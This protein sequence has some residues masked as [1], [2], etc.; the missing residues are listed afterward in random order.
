MEQL[1]EAVSQTG[2]IALMLSVCANIALAWAHVVWRREERADRRKMQETM[3]HVT[4]AMN[5]VKIV[6]S[7]QLGRPIT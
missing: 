7:A 4:E 2:N 3:D 6:L 5:G 1:I